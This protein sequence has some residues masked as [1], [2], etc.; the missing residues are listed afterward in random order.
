MSSRW[1][2]EEINC[3][4]NYI[5]E[6]FSMYTTGVKEIFYEKASEQEFI[7]KTKSQVKTKC[8][9]L[10]SKYKEYKSKFNTSGFG[11]EDLEKES[12]KSTITF[13]IY[14]FFFF[15][16]FFQYYFLF[17]FLFFFL[18]IYLQFVLYFNFFIY[19]IFRIIF[20]LEVLEKKFPYYYV[21]DEIFGSRHNIVPPILL[22]T[23]NN[24]PQYSS[25][26][27]LLGS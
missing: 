23:G 6:N 1:S 25:V 21:M 7:N 3:L 18:F 27:I 20:V 16:F 26:E 17:Y 9:V 11:I 24:D 2:S 5:A 4:I 15:G 19:F 14:F 10:E 22:D 8:I 12:F 13:I